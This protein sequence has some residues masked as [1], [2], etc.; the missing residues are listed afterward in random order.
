MKKQIDKILIPTDYSSNARRAV[1]FGLAL[2]EQV[3]AEVLLFHSYHF[4]MTTSEDMVYISKMKEGEQDK[5]NAEKEAVAEKYPNVKID[6]QVEYGSAVDL[7]ETIAEREGVDLIV[8]GTKGETNGLDA[9]LGSVASNSINNVKCSTIVIPEETKDF[10][11]NHIM[12][13]TDFHE[14]KNHDFYGPLLKILDQTDA[15]VSVV[16]VKAAIDLKEVPSKEEIET[17]N[18]FGEYKHSHHFLEAENIEEALF[19]FAHL[20]DCDMIVI[21]TKHYNLWQRLWHKSMAKQLALHTT[22]PLFIMHEDV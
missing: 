5:L 16:N 11:I 8:M 14:T 17:D 15:A 2:A 1:N 7:I 21:L 18:I 4:P 22:I 9:V 3:N 6:A 10:E 13:A 19:D 20:N 12:V